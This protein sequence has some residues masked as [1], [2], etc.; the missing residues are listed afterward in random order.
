MPVTIRSAR[1]DDLEALRA[2]YDEFQSFHVRGLPRYLRVPDPGEA[3][4]TEFDQAVERLIAGEEAT[5]LVAESDGRLV[6]LAEVYLNDPVESPFVVSR[7]TATLQSLLV[8]EDFR[9]TGLGRA[10]VEAVEQWALQRGAKEMKA[11]TWE[12]PEG[13]LAFYEALGYA[14]LS[15]ELVKPLA[16]D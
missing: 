5:L 11:K 2:G 13:P 7:R 4:P 8:I 1:P 9:G 16:E 15:R 6:G 14:T 10:L 3:G 12:F